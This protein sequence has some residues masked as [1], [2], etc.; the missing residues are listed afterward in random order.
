MSQ[1]DLLELATRLAARARDSEQV[2]AFVSKGRQFTVRAYDGD[3]ESL[4]SA[5]AAGI[6]VRVI[7]GGR[8]GFAHA[9]TLDASAIDEVIADA[10][11][12]LEFGE[13][14]Q[15]FALAE[16]DGVRPPDLQLWSEELATMAPD[17]KVSMA[18][19]LERLVKEGD[20][21]I[22]G[23][24][25][26]IWGDSV[27]EVAIATSTGVA[28]WSQGSSCY[29]MVQ[30]LAADGN[31]TQTGYGVDVGR[32]PGEIDLGA[33]AADAV[34]RATRM[35]GAKQPPSARLTVVLDRRVA[36]DFLSI[37]SG[38]LTGEVVLK[39]RSP[40]ADRLGE[41]I[42][43]PLLSIVDD[44][45]NPQSLGSDTHDGEGLATRPTTLI[46]AGALKAF[47]HNSYTGRRSG[48][49]TTASAVRGYSSAPS[50]GCLALIPTIGTKS[51]DEL[52]ADV[53]EGLLVHSVA[54]LHSGVNPVSGDFSVGAE[55]MMIR[56]GALAEPV[57]E[58]TIASTLQK[59]LLDI[60]AVGGDLEWLPGGDA[61]VSLVIRDV[62]LSGR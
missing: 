44:A 55:G 11:D 58:I 53:G 19:D 51:L 29:V 24:R 13:P 46:D 27:G 21:R 1:P 20:P 52:I 56:N 8:Q 18:L 23:V 17:R 22:T 4:T 41:T 25:T 49:G 48:S 61:G 14:D 40:F 54:G 50:V 60:A 26:A 3:V 47:L 43:S 36:A 28:A 45:T 62:A 59:M 6:G 10:R 57:R 30:S 5:E 42:A 7:K 16:P 37:V 12:N 32:A 34:D 35:L 33:T 39:R 9:G 31:E 38:M 15:W 2:E